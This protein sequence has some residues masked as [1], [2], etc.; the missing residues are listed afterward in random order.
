[1]STWLAVGLKAVLRTLSSR[2]RH[3]TTINCVFTIVPVIFSQHSQQPELRVI[4]LI[5]N[6]LPFKSKNY[7]IYFLYTNLSSFD[8]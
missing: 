1:M 5:A 3:N 7:F 6:L 2:W 4:Q 8:L